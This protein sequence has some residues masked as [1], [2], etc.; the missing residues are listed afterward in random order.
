[1]LEKTRVIGADGDVYEK[2]RPRQ[3]TPTGRH[4]CAPISA[5][6]AHFPE[7]PVCLKYQIFRKFHPRLAAQ[8]QPGS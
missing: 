8:A 2:A 7:V 4:C 3:N 1:M 6:P 5:E